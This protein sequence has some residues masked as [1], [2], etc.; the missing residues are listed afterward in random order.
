MNVLER[1][2]AKREEA[3]K[4]IL[5]KIRAKREALEE[6]KKDIEV[7]RETAAIHVPPV[8]TYC[9]TRVRYGRSYR[10][11]GELCICSECDKYIKKENDNGRRDFDKV[12]KKKG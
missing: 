4:G 6:V 10:K 5:D 7:R 3:K 2:K 12:R 11:A 1:I 9:G 8:C